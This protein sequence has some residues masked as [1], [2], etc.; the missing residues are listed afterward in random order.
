MDMMIKATRQAYSCY[1]CGSTIFLHH[2]KLCD[3]AE[4][5]A[6]RDLP[7]EPGTQYWTGKTTEKQE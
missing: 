6:I 2:T 3:L 5:N 7:A 4:P 1:D